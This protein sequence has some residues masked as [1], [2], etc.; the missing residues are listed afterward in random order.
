MDSIS[1]VVHLR[2][3]STS[4]KKDNYLSLDSKISL[5]ADPNSLK[6][7]NTLRRLLKVKDPNYSGLVIYIY[8]YIHTHT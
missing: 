7:E 3:S 4:L 5:I 1:I 8:I 6:Y 2:G